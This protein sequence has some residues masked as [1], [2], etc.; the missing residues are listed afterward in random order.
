MAE[1]E[2]AFVSSPQNMICV[3]K[4]IAATYSGHVLLAK[5]KG[6]KKDNPDIRRLQVV[7]RD[8][9]YHN[10]SECHVMTSSSSQ[11]LLAVDTPLPGYKSH[12]HNPFGSSKPD[13]NRCSGTRATLRQRGCRWQSSPACLG[14]SLANETPLPKACAQ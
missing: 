12:L 8:K 5:T 11:S 7:L 6:A 10:K 1:S 3:V 14:V 2:A 13:G 9:Q 4:R